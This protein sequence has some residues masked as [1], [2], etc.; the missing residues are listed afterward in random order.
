MI[1]KFNEFIKEGKI[2]K[3]P[4]T[5]FDH[6]VKKITITIGDEK[7]EALAGANNG[8]VYMDGDIKKSDTFYF[9]TDKK[10]TTILKNLGLTDIKMIDNTKNII[11][12]VT[13]DGIEEY[14]FKIKWFSKKQVDSLED[15][16]EGGFV[17]WTLI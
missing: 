10:N 11:K 9:K 5:S 3:L 1:T 7:V 4:D 15:V 8:Y 6:N 17:S 13:D 2:N 16:E 14:K 12:F